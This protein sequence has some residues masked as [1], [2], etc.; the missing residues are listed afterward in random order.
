MLNL[1]T[2][3]LLLLSPIDTTKI[4]VNV[5][6]VQ[7]IQTIGGRDVTFGVKE[8]V[9]ELLIEKRKKDLKSNGL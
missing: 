8:T 2:P 3:I 1:L 9:E 5:I 4:N 7:H 6:N